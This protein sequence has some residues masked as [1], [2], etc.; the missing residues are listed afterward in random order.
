MC[1]VV[2]NNIKY[3]S[4]IILYFIIVNKP[5]EKT[6]TNNMLVLLTMLCGSLSVSLKPYSCQ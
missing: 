3:K 1:C 5:H 4:G 2:S 6:N